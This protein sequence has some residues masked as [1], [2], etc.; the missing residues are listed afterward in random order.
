MDVTAVKARDAWI[1][2]RGAGVEMRSSADLRGRADMRRSAT[3][4]MRDSAA[5]A[6]KMRGAAATAKVRSAAATTAVWGTA[7]TTMRWGRIR[8]RC[9]AKRKA[10]RRRTRRNFQHGFLVR[11]DPK[12]QRQACLGRSSKLES[13]MLQRTG[14]DP[15]SGASFEMWQA[16]YACQRA[17]T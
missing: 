4:E 14:T 13:V 1:E 10:N 9:Q 7:A 17:A 3:A 15:N 5:T 16:A 6:A 8:G 2:M 11:T 12:R